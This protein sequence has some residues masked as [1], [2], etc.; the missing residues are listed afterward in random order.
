MTADIIP[1]TGTWSPWLHPGGLIHVWRRPSGWLDVMHESASGESYG[2]IASYP[3]DQKVWA[4]QRA[5][6]SLDEY[7]P[8]SLG[9][10]HV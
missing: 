6:E 5:I 10:V 9:E 7:A 8:C 2:T 4:V 3:P 1:F